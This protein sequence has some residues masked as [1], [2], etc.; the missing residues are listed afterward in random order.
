MSKKKEP[1]KTANKNKAS[2]SSSV[3]KKIFSSILLW[4]IIIVLLS[5][6][7]TL[8]VVPRIKDS[9]WTTVLGIFGSGLATVGTGFIVGY[10]IDVKKNTAEYTKEIGN[11]LKKII[12]DKTFVRTLNDE[13]KL[14]ICEKL[15]VPNE[16]RRHSDIDEYM[17]SKSRKFLDFFDINFRTNFTVTVEV[18]YDKTLEKYKSKYS[19]SYHIYKINNEYKPIDIRFEK[20]SN[21]YDTIIK[22]NNNK[23]LKTVS[24]KDCKPGKY[25]EAIEGEGYSYNIPQEYYKYPF[26]IIER[27]VVEYGHKHWISLNWSSLTP[28]RDLTYEVICQDGIIK[29][30]YIFDNS[31]L[32]EKP[33]LSDNRKR[34]VIKSTQW[35][36]PYTGICVIVAN[37]SEDDS[38]EKSHSEIERGRD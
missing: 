38:F 3:I 13:E 16:S 11:E 6:I 15:I 20:E 30:Y 12:V 1:D 14:S 35:V 26:L 31:D 22:S 21:L 7:V 33:K 37:P 18:S 25:P 23:K 9:F 32:Y 5:I 8:I 36:D 2:D 10:A 34:M 4:G 29:D 19:F 17:R 27:N 24:V 28:I